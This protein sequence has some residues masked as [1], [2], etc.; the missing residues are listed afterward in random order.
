MSF[1][2]LPGSKKDKLRKTIAEMDKDEHGRQVLTDRY[3]REL[4]EENG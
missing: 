1:K 2:P 4:C 3:L